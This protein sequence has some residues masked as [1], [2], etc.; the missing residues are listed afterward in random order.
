MAAFDLSREV[1]RS[2]IL[3]DHFE[4]HAN[5]LVTKELGRPSE[6]ISGKEICFRALVSDSIL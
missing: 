1:V 3:M 4:R 6:S 2:F 5:T